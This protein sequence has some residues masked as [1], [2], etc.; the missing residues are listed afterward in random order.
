MWGALG[1]VDIGE[2]VSEKRGGYA[3]IH[4]CV[5]SMV[6]EFCDFCMS[7]SCGRLWCKVDTD[8]L[9]VFR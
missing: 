6:C 4:V 2:C 9:S 1:G 3:R 5:L 8:I 7:F